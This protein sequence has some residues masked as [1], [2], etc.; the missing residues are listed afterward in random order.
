M[1]KRYIANLARISWYIH[2]LV[3]NGGLSHG[4]SDYERET[5]Q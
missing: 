3:S 1:S 2:D 5:P 4:S